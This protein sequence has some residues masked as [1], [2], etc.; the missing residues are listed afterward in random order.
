M[1]IEKKLQGG[2]TQRE[3]ILILFLITAISLSL[4]LYTVDFSTPLISDSTRYTLQA[5]SIS[6][7]DFKIPSDHNLGWPIFISPFTFLIQSENFLDYSVLV[8]LLSI[9][10]ST[11]TIWFLYLLGKR[12]FDEKYSLI[13][14]S[15]FAFEPHLN[16]ISS[17]GFIEPLFILVFIT[18]YYFILK[19]RYYS[20]LISFFFVG[21]LYWLKLTS[22]IA[23]VA[24]S[25]IFLINTR[26]FKRSLIL[27][28]C[29]GIFFLLIYPTMYER[30]EEY[31][32]P[33]YFIF[34]D[35][36]FVEDYSIQGKEKTSAQ[37]Y[38][39]K[40]GLYPFIEK[41][42][43]NGSLNVLSTLARI[44][45]P[46]LIF[47][48]PIGMILSFSQFDLD[49]NRVRANWT[50]LIISLLVMI[51]PFAS[52]A[53]KR[54]L[55]FIYPILIIFATLAI[56]RITEH[57]LNA[58]SF[59]KKKKKLFLILLMVIILIISTLFTLRFER[60]DPMEE[61]EKTTWTKFLL[62]NIN[63]KITDGGYAIPYLVPVKIEESKGNFLN[64]KIEDQ[65]NWPNILGGNLIYASSYGKGIEEY[66]KYGESVG[67]RYIGI[68]SKGSDLFPFLDEVY[69]EEKKYPFLVKVYDSKDL[70]FQRYFV[71]V[72]E[73]D[74]K[75]FHN[76]FE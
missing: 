22:L 68:S 67:L 9:S 72:F 12:F 1:Q 44:S 54:F 73:I 51:I 60:P 59:S 15:L 71:K 37:I 48:F 66:I 24:F 41:F 27:V 42:F 8:R 65:K 76:Y 35:I 52:V 7:G 45:F 57:G 6:Q 40:H 46:Y 33:F 32:N 16:Y 61:A 75:K 58:F 13:M 29:F 20:T 34:V 5:I 50:L 62:R 28:A 10:I 53:E 38:I 23:L 25:I 17:F 39:Q 69:M 63:G 18:S 74:Y 31:G 19:Q 2:I 11:I 64:Y 70:G 3:V 14:V 30:Y 47:L 43:I 55:Y 49:K 4:K 36:F 26:N 21:I 56:K